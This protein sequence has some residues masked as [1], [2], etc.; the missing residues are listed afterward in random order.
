MHGV[1][2]II[3]IVWAIGTSIAGADVLK[4]KKS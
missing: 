1:I 4:I 2:S 3:E